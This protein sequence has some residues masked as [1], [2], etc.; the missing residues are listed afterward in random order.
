MG[1]DALRPGSFEATF[2]RP[3]LDDDRRFVSFSVLCLE[4]VSS[5]AS[6]NVAGRSANDICRVELELCRRL[7][8][9]LL[10]PL[11]SLPGVWAWD[12]LFLVVGA[13]RGLLDLLGWPGV[14]ESMESLDCL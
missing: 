11:D 6:L 14:L 12:E 7:V 8:E 9:L 13:F 5:S 2:R 1:S 3:L 10:L 4:S